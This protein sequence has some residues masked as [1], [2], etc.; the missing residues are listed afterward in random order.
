MPKRSRQDSPYPPPSPS[1]DSGQ[2]TRTST[3]VHTQS[4]RASTEPPTHSN[5][6]IQTSHE[7]P[8]ARTAMKCSLPPHHETLAFP[9]FE[10]FEI[11]YNKVHANRCTECRRNFPTEHFLGL[12][13]SENHDPLEEARRAKGEKTVRLPLPSIFLSHPFV[14]RNHD[15]GK[16]ITH[17]VVPLLRSRLRQTLLHSA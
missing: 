15:C 1:S 16:L 4:S 6:Y 8:R 2:S 3:D 17:L 11:H 10:D 7:T 5:K 13:I 12:H 9:T 14:R